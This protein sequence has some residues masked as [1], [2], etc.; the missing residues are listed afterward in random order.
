MGP[1]ESK[2][3]ELYQNVL[4]V[5]TSQAFIFG[6]VQAEGKATAMGIARLVLPLRA[7]AISV[8]TSVAICSHHG[9]CGVSQLISEVSTSFPTIMVSSQW[10]LQL[11][12]HQL[13]WSIRCQP[14]IFILKF[15]SARTSSPG[16]I[17]WC[18]FKRTMGYSRVMQL[19]SRPTDLP[20]STSL[21]TNGHQDPSWYLA[22]QARYSMA[23]MCG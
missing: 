12:T 3:I 9:T 5:D 20:W 21:H 15:D 19:P 16:Q 6:L 22:L 7:W 11:T 17:N 8:E 2:W 1:N 18:F 4:D 14:L 13:L 10:E 23:S